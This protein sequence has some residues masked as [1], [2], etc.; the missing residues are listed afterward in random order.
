MT[1]FARTVWYV[2]TL[3]C[4]EAD[5]LRSVAQTEPLTRAERFGAWSHTTLCKSCRRARRQADILQSLIRDLSDTPAEGALSD[6][7]R[8][9]IA[10]AIDENPK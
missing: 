1:R 7:A 9:R 3:R 5:R 8:M 6:G 2:L 4:E 10:E